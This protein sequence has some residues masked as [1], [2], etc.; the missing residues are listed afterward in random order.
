MV[1]V[2]R[3]GKGGKVG[4]G[5]KRL[6]KVGKGGKDL[7]SYVRVDSGSWIQMH[8]SG[9]FQDLILMLSWVVDWLHAP[10]NRLN[11]SMKVVVPDGMSR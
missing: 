3:V 11:F 4:K 10:R 1:K 5:W 7:V 8:T 9:P 2:V 6:V